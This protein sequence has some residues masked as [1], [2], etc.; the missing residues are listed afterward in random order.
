MYWNSSLQLDENKNPTEKILF[1]EYR[2]GTFKRYKRISAPK[3][4]YGNYVTII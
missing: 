4:E 2:S 1:I 3:F